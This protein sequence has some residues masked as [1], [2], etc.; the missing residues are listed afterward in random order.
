MSEIQTCVRKHNKTIEWLTLKGMI[1][2]GV[3]WV[4]IFFV[5]LIS[6]YKDTHFVCLK[7]PPGV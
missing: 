7:Y 3:V 4:S 5:I 2:H 6:Q 1:A